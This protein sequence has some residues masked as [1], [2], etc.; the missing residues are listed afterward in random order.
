MHVQL[1]FILAQL[2]S[3]ELLRAAAS[4]RLAA[5]LADADRLRASRDGQVALFERLSAE[6]RRGRLH[7]FT[8][9]LTPREPHHLSDVDHVRHEA[10]GAIE[11]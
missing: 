6:S 10:F 1:N 7:T 3:D 2:R 4:A 11:E 5:S 8:Q 9:R